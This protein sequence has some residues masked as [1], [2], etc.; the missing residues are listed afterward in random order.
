MKKYISLLLVFIFT[1]AVLCGAS[2]ALGT[3]ARYAT[4]P[5]NMRTGPSTKYPVIRELQTGEEVELVSTEG[6]WAKVVSGG[7]EGYVFAKYLSKEKPLSTGTML[8]AK[9]S[10]NVRSKPTSAS[11]KLGKL[12]KGESVT[13]VAIRGRWAEIDWNGTSAY[14]YRKYFTEQSKSDEAYQFAGAVT[15]FF[16][17][18]YSEYLLG[19][20]L[21]ND[22]GKLCIRVTSN[23]NTAKIMSAL[24]KTDKVDAGSISILTS[25]LPFYANKDYVSD[26]VS[27]F[28]SQ[29]FA[30]SSQIQSKIRLSAAGYS[31]ATDKITVELI[32]LDSAA[33]DAFRTYISNAEYITFTS[34]SNYDVPMV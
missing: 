1:A 8:I 17:K 24:E 12:Q 28:F 33:Q 13:L 10:V 29:Y 3:Q 32:N 30:L 23:A 18:N 20:Y 21:D 34:A 26:M 5:V 2:L 27:G 15:E 4:E 7:T 6:K 22:S 9:R 14:V 16:E 11:K 19:I 31:P 25:S